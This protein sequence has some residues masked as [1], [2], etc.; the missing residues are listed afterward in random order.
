MALWHLVVGYDPDNI[1]FGMLKSER[2]QGNA[3]T[4]AE[5]FFQHHP[6]YRHCIA[7]CIDARI[8]GPQQSYPFQCMPNGRV[9]LLIAA[10][11]D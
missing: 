11:P 9:V 7:T 10:H 6:L 8:K 2:W 4:A 3:Q 5:A 1:L